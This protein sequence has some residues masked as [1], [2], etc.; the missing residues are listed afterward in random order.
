MRFVY[1]MDPLETMHPDERATLTYGLDRVA[2]R[3]L[4]I[5]RP[6]DALDPTRAALDF[7]GPTPARLRRLQAIHARLGGPPAPR[8]RGR[9]G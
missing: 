4:E 1:V 7:G 8:G 9:D 2:D 6:G 3:L 5:N